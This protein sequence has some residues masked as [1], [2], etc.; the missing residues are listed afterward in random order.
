MYD[1]MRLCYYGSTYALI[2]VLTY[3][4]KKYIQVIDVKFGILKK[5]FLNNMGSHNVHTH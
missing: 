3:V 5:L 1:R 4:L 2:G